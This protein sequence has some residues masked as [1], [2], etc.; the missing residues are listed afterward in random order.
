MS[1]V[2]AVEYRETY[3]VN[4]NFKIALVTRVPLQQLCSIV[5][6]PLLLLVLAEVALE[7][8]LAPGAVDGVRNWREC[9]DRLVFARVAKV[10]LAF[11]RLTI[12][13]IRKW[14]RK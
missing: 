12:H 9:R 4:Q 13:L 3:H 8:L 2:T 1:L 11:V 6:L 5:L 10:L 7:G 14:Q